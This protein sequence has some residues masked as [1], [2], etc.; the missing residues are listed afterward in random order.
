MI[1]LLADLLGWAGALIVLAAYGGVSFRKIHPESG[2]YQ[3]CNALGGT[4]LVINTA[5]YHAYP[6]TLVNVVWIGIA[7]AA[8][9]R[10]K[11]AALRA[12]ETNR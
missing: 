11:P 10:M 2:W 8:R 7:L 3:F 4:F 12:P 5:Y 9:A 6:S 1:K